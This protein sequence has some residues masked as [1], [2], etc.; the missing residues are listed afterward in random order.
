MLKL[1]LICNDPDLARFA[2]DCGVDRIFVD[3]EVLGKEARQG[4]RDTVISHHSIAD[5][6]RVRKA[7][8]NA[9]LLVRLNPLHAGSVDEVEQVLS[10][11][12]NLLMLPMFRRTAELKK[13]AAHVAGRAGIIP[14]VETL[15]AVGRLS[16]IVKVP[17]V[18]EIYIGLN[19]LHIELGQTFIFESLANGTLDRITRV[20]RN[21]GIPFGFGGIARMGEGLLHAEMVLG[22]H[23][24][25][26]SS[27]VILSRTFHRHGTGK[28]ELIDQQE[29]KAEISKLR[30]KE[31]ELMRRTPEQQE[32]DRHL[33][34]GIVDDIVRKPRDG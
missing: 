33:L 27:S 25:L 17:G 19:D 22:E 1:M 3:L 10:A 16:D 32:T 24:R 6:S 21:A 14:L 28:S 29:F 34:A 31:A 23:L 18:S 15:E 30:E 13:F 2:V 9:E 11:G 4:H 20:I 12:A 7:V 5:V 26:G 8:P